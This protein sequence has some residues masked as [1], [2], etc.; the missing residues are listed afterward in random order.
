MFKTMGEDLFQGLK[1]V[2]VEE[3]EVIASEAE[4]D[5]PGF[6]SNAP[7]RVL[8]VDLDLKY[9]NKKDYRM[10]NDNAC[11]FFNGLSMRSAA[12]YKRLKL[13]DDEEYLRA[14]ADTNLTHV[15]FTKASLLEDIRLLKSELK[16]LK[17]GITDLKSDKWK[18]PLRPAAKPNDGKYIRARTFTI[19][20]TAQIVRSLVEVNSM[21]AEINT[22]AF[23][24]EVMKRIEVL[25]DKL[26]A[27]DKELL[28]ITINMISIYRLVN[29]RILNFDT[30]VTEIAN[31]LSQI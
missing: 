19:E 14:L 13:Y 17:A 31:R 1:T 11:I 7:L 4:N 12:Y 27:K 29:E 25:P 2:V 18:E 16:S 26:D 21:L 5:Y 20:D 22:K 15:R 6:K 28:G 30:D 9:L 3:T 8:E 10:L 23:E 24:E